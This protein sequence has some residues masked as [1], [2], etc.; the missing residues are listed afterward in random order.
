MPAVGRK[1]L[2]LSVQS[3]GSWVGA[4]LCSVLGSAPKGSATEPSAYRVPAWQLDHK[5]APKAFLS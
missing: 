3:A 2:Y 1:Q 5:V 4:L